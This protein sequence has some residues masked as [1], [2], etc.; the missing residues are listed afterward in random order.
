[1]G[2]AQLVRFL[3][4]ELIYPDS[5]FRFDMCVAFTANYSFSGG[6]VPVNSDALL[7]T[8]FDSTNADT[9]THMSTHLYEHTQAHTTPMSTSER[10]CRLDLEIH[11]VGHQ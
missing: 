3:V 9:H 10:L 11:E 5:N 8:D 6:D 2:L 7:V 4:V 1:V